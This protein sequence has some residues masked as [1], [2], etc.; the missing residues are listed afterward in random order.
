MY[1]KRYIYWTLVFRSNNYS[2]MNDY[3][4][5]GISSNI[6]GRISDVRQL[7]GLSDHRIVRLSTT[8]SYPYWRNQ[9][10]ANN[11]EPQLF[12]NVALLV[13]WLIGVAQE[14]S[15]IFS[16]L[17]VPPQLSSPKWPFLPEDKRAK[18]VELVEEHTASNSFQNMPSSLK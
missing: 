17:S 6:K 9:N 3:T 13:W 14:D 2:M 12:Q 4:Y 7:V 15:K 11:C 1:Q 10:Q 16:F 5:L 18:E 8:Q